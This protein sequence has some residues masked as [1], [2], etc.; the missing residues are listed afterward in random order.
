V[1]E[2]ALYPLAGC[3]V[4]LTRPVA[5]NQALQQAIETLGATVL[6]LPMLVIRAVEPSPADKDRILNLDNYNLVFFVS[7]NAARIGLDLI[8]NFW[9]QYPLGIQNFAVGSGT[10]AVIE[11]HGLAVVYPQERM[12]SEA[13]LALPE[14]QQIRGKK[15][16]IVRG[17]GGREILA[18]GLEARGCK[19]DY[20]ELYERLPAIWQKDQLQQYLQERYPDAVVFSSAE[21]MDNFAAQFQQTG[22]AWISLPL[23]VAS[24]RL[25]KHAQGLGFENIRVM[26]GAG[27]EAIISALLGEDSK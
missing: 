7:T 14:L 2:K 21:A 1:N 25:E 10:A 15:A 12:S 5:Q 20:A 22:T 17:V 16:L 24:E 8:G 11:S 23:L 4:W 13:M 6:S 18:S 26:A 27:D 9:P 3:T 19:V